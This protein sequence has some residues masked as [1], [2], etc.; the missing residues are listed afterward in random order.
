MASAPDEPTLRGRKA[1]PDRVGTRLAIRAAMHA[2]TDWGTAVAVD[3]RWLAGLQDHNTS[4]RR[5]G[6]FLKFCVG[7]LGIGCAVSA[8]FAYRE[9]GHVTHLSRQV[10]E[11]AR[12][13]HRNDLALGALARSH[14]SILAATENAP[15]IGTRSWAHRFTVT[16]YVPRSEAYGR[17]NHGITSTLMKADPAA[18]IVAVDPKLIP[19]G[20][21]VWI[22]SL[23]WFH[24]QDCGSAIKGYR[25]DVLV[26]TDREAMDYGK[27]DRFVIVIPPTDGDA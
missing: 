25:L 4:L 26:P 14:E 23:G 11:F 27:Q 9:A 1:S 13:A 10:H 21:S 7:V 2:R 5:I 16:Q 19:Y 15:S 12:T 22:E 24:A 3:P 20:S 6:T 8:T 18:R 17:F